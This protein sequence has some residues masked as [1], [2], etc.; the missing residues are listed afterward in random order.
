MSIP[1]GI[2]LHLLDL[3]LVA[4]LVLLALHSIAYVFSR[5][6]CVSNGK[7]TFLKF[8]TNKFKICHWSLYVQKL[9]K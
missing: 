3:E 9:K 4:L 7:L 5:V 1:V 8:V 2:L 6:F